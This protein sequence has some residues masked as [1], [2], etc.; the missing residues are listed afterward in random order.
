[1]LNDFLL[2]VLTGRQTQAPTLA[3]VRWAD[4]VRDSPL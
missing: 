2:K 1:M 4:K 3:L